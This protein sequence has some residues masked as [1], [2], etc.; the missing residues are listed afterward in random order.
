MACS[1]RNPI[2]CIVPELVLRNV[3]E[4]GNEQQRRAA[5]K[6]LGI[7]QTL[8][9]ARVEAAAWL[10]S[11]GP[12]RVSAA[13]TLRSPA[14]ERVI[15]NAENGSDLAA[16]AVRREGDGDSGD[17]A[18]DEAYEYLGDT[19][20][21]FFEVFARDSIDQNGMTLDAVV[22][23]E[24][25]FDNAFWNGEQM[26]FGDGSG[27]FTRLTK[28]LSVC[29]HELGHGV[30]QFDGPLVY[31]TQSGALNE[32]IADCFGAMVDQYKQGQTAD[33]ASWLIGAEILGED[34]TGRAL[35]D[36]ANP[37]TA[38][39]D[40]VLGKDPQPGHMDDYVETSAD[41]G[42][43]HINSGI[44]NRAFHTLATTLGGHSWE[45]AGRILYA[46]L[47]HPRLRANTSF[48]RF[49]RLNLHVARTLYGVGSEQ[50]DAV[51]TAWT[52][53]GVEP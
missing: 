1:C 52:T 30:I 6:T 9:S 18:I 42:G 7:D 46:T 45:H 32:S 39:E 10:A 28:S 37:G 5:L 15:R 53:V 31:Q 33:A 11:A 50:V 38:F 23:Y 13:R 17:P 19:W 25:D 12:P 14:V 49:A 2:H 3:A 4:H 35:R 26:V 22:H 51:M 41:R 40:D 43:V 36:M 21:F 44:P 16:P 34:V 24:Q 8:R 20:D 29:G 48:R 47:G 27:L